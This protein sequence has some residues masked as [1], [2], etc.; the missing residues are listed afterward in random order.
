LKKLGG[1]ELAD[2][3]WAP[4]MAS[5][6]L[7]FTDEHGHGCEVMLNL[8]HGAHT[9]DADTLLRK[10]RMKMRY[11]PTVDV[12]ARGHCHHLRQSSEERMVTDRRNKRVHQ[13][14]VFVILTGGYGKSFED[15][16]AEALDLDPID[17]GMARLDI[18]P[19]R[20]GAHLEVVT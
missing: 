12:M 19:S 11:W 8:H 7:L 20:H 9:G 13:R 1:E 15:G 6:Q 2:R 10:L 18:F 17:I 3:L 4:N 5:V 16:Y 14:K